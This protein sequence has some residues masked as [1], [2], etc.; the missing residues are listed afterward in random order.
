MDL[1]RELIL[2]FEHDDVSIPDGYT[3]SEVAYHVK[4]MVKSGL[5]EASVIEAPSPGKMKPVNFIFRDITPAGHDFIAAMKDAGF[6]AKLKRE[7]TNRAAP[8]TLDLLLLVA[9]ELGKKAFFLSESSQVPKH[10]P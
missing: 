1:I 7:A 5:I 3:M 9:K 6:W 8:M 4:Q 10:D 2:N